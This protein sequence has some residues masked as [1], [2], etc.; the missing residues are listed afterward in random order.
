MSPVGL[1][2]YLSPLFCTLTSVFEPAWLQ[3]SASFLFLLCFT[4]SLILIFGPFCVCNTHQH[5][6]QDHKVQH[7]FLGNYKSAHVGWTIDPLI[8]CLGMLVV[9]Q[10]EIFPQFSSGSILS[11]CWHSDYWCT[12]KLVPGGR[13]WEGNLAYSNMSEYELKSWKL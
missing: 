4:Q 7:Y 8:V 12:T 9:G 11:A 13:G 1:V 5:L 2:K 10:G 3:L 6:R